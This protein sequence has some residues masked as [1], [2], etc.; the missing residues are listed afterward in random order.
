[1]RRLVCL[2][3]GVVLVAVS[4]PALTAM[5]KS[6]PAAVRLGYRP[7]FL[8]SYLVSLEYRHLYSQLLFYDATF[9][10]GALVNTPQVKPDYQSIGRYL[11]DATRLNPYNIDAYYLAQAVLTWDAGLVRDV[12]VMLDRGAKRRTWDFYLPFFL[13]FNYAYFLNDPAT[14]VQYYA[15]AAK[16]N[17]QMSFLPTYVG[18]L[19]YEADKTEQ[20]IEYLKVVHQGTFNDAVRR[21]IAVRIS[22][23]E[24]IRFLEGAVKKY[25]DKTG[26]PL[27]DLSQ[28]VAAGILKEIPP[29]PYGGHFYYDSKD[30][31]IRT[32]SKLASQGAKN[33]RH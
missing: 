33:D 24:A 10:Y 3:L 9:Y 21:S 4:L 13:G 22:A 29:D 31:R 7:S 8:V 28:L 1:M 26:R 18:R 32:T 16:L 5:R 20:A 27:Q 25:Q 30:G 15:T 6:A 17:P 12:N 2:I 11:N 19:Y 14:A 23:L